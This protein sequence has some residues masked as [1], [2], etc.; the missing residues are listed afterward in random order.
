MTS[1]FYFLI[2]RIPVF[3]AYQIENTTVSI[4][5]KQYK[6]NKNQ[7][8]NKQTKTHTNHSN[9]IEITTTDA[10]GKVLALLL[11]ISNIYYRI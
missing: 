8:N 4:N 11:T 10:N 1:I 5:G 6:Q 7:I 2:S 9:F 3:P